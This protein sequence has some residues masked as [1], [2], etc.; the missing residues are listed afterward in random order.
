MTKREWEALLTGKCDEVQIVAAWADRAI[1]KP[2]TAADHL[3]FSQHM[4]REAKVV[5][6]SYRRHF[7]LSA[8]A[9]FVESHYRV[10]P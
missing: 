5:H 6:P 9:W 3:K 10:K 8:I 4:E 1:G 2:E 7:R